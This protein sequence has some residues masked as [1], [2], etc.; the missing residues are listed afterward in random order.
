MTLIALAG[1]PGA[2]KSTL[3]HVL[4]AELG[5]PVF[6]KDTVRAALFAPWFLP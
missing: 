6:D 5:A 1:L 3:A 2:G 4:A